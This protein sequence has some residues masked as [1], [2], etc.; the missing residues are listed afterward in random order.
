MPALNTISLDKLDRQIGIPKG[1]VIIDVQT[2]EDFALDPRLIP[3]AV[4]R[5]HENGFEAQPRCSR[6]AAT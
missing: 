4:R 6:L 2:D 1:P 5:S 3:G